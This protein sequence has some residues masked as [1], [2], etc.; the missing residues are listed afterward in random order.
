MVKTA[1]GQWLFVR[2]NM[3]EEIALKRCES[4]I[5]QVGGEHGRRHYSGAHHLIGL[6][7]PLYVVLS[8]LTPIEGQMLTVGYGAQ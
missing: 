8:E 7:C 5:A 3:A 2:A 4:R 1:T 6:I